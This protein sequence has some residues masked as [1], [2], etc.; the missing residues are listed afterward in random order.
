MN[1]CSEYAISAFGDMTVADELKYFKIHLD[2][3]ASLSLDHFVIYDK[4][5]AKSQIKKT[6][7]DIEQDDSNYEEDGGIRIDTKVEI[8]FYKFK[9]FS[10]LFDVYNIDMKQIEYSL[11]PEKNKEQVFQSGEGSG[12]SGSFFFFSHDKRFIIK[13]MTSSELKTFLKM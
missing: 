12:K 2:G 5:V 3:N 4:E 1:K 8:L 6:S 9:S 13:T 7:A 11:S 10:E